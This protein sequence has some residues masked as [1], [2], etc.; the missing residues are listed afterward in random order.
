M[1]RDYSLNIILIRYTPLC[2][3][4]FINFRPISLTSLG[5]NIIYA[6]PCNKLQL[7]LEL[8]YLKLRLMQFYVKIAMEISSL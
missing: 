3:Q 8:L 5:L 1:L 4:A 2:I 7:R 6:G